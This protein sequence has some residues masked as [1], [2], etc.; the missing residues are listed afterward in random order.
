M[1]MTRCRL[2]RNKRCRNSLDCFSNEK[3]I[4]VFVGLEY[5]S[6]K[7]NHTKKVEKNEKNT[8]KRK[9]RKIAL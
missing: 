4:F 2:N 3:V 6:M 5:D 8:E 9:N 7:P 1:Y